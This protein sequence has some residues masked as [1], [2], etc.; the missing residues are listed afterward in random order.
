MKQIAWVIGR[1]LLGSSVES[2][3]GTKLFAAPVQ[4]FSWSD[5]AELSHE[6]SK[7]IDAFVQASKDAA[8]TVYWMAGKGVMNTEKPEM[9]KETEALTAFLHLFKDRVMTKGTF[10]L[11]SSAGGVYA[12]SRDEVINELTVPKPTS[13]Y[14]EEKLKQEEFVKEWATSTGNSA[15]IA[16]IANLYGPGQS[17]GKKQGLITHVARSMLQ[18]KPI[19]IFVPFDTMRDYIHVDDAGADLIL[20]AQMLESG[21]ILTKI[22]ASEESTTVAAIIGVFRRITRRQ[23]LVVTAST[24]F[25]ATYP[26]CASFRSAVLPES[27]SKNRT[28][29]LNGVAGVLASERLQLK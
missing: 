10:V 29:L 12:G 1:G 9:I 26:H 20:A 16:R 8:W 5:A 18:R 27:R 13:A 3:I 21:T 28:S 22:I 2:A 7:S 11:A 25:G 24:P 6:F 4:H 19:H 23:P 17:K 14:G 15:L